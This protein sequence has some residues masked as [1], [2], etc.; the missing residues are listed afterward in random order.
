MV[1]HV[2]IV[3]LGSIGLRHL[4]LLEDL[5]PEMELTIVR[6]G[7]GEGGANDLAYR[8]VS[9]IKEA[10]QS[11]IQAAIIASPASLHIMQAIELAESGIH[12]LIEKPLASSLKD[13]G[14]LKGIVQKNGLVVTV[15]YIL[16]YDPAAQYFR[17]CL[18]AR[19]VGEPLHAHVE[20]GSYLPDW[21]PGR[22]Y[23]RSVSARR[24]LGGGALLELSH[25]LDYLLW[26]FGPM[27]EVV[28][29]F[30][31]CGTLSLDVE[32]TVQMLL[33]S[34]DLLP[35]AVHLDFNRRHAVRRCVLHGS[36]GELSWDAVASKVEIRP[37]NGPIKSRIFTQRRDDLFKAQ[38]THF[39]GCIELG[40]QPV[41]SLDDGQQTLE[42]IEE[43]RNSSRM[44]RSV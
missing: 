21:R 29:R 34:K 35:I 16:R 43:A 8:Q 3:G 37:V 22:D 11:G 4:R 10:I 40:N 12:L 17:E 6:S 26:F 32:D 44:G 24:E 18:M 1:G 39:L 23:R 20:C 7:K 42:L 38:L 14:K 28:A 33:R 25:E 2:A 19:C 36:K 31:K 9:S 41:V 13:V 27:S 30:Y 15:G 5:R